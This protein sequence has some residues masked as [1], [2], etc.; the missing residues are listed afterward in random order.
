MSYAVVKC[1]GKQVRV[2]E[3]ATIRVEKL[4]HKT[5]ETVT[6]DQ[7]LLI[8]DGKEVKI[9]APRV[10]GASVIGQIVRQGRGKKLMVFKDRNRKGIRRHQGHRQAFTELKI[11][12]I[13]TG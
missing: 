5:G 13:V 4:A 11:Q 12:K 8:S 7:V 6:L 1:G 9:G 10:A 2:S 3:G